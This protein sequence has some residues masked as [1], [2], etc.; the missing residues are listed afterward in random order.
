MLLSGGKDSTYALAQLKEMGL[1]VLAFTL[2]NGY[3]SAEALANVERVAT[4]L[5]VDYVIGKTEAMNAIFV[6]SLQ[7]H[8]NVC[9]GCFKTIYTL[10][11]QLALEKQ[12]PFIV[13]GLSRGQFFETRLTKELFEK[14]EVDV[15][16]IDEMILNARKA[17]HQVDD[18]V[19]E[20][21]DV[22]M[23]DNDYAF[24]KV[25]FLDFYRYTDVS[26]NEM[27]VYLNN[28]LPWVRP[29]DTGRSTNCLINQ[30]GIYIHKKEL[31]YSNYAFP[32]SW[33]VRIGHKTRKES[34]D[35]IN[36]K[37]DEKEVLQIL[38]EIGYT[39]AEQAD[40]RKAQ[41]VAY[42]VG[43]AVEE[44]ELKNYL[45]ARFPDYMIPVQ[46]IPL[47]S[48]PLT[49]NGKIDKAALPLPDAIRPVIATKYQ[50]PQTEFEEIIQE[51]WSEVMDI[52]KIGIYDTFIALG[53]DSLQGIQ[54]ISRLNAAFEL[55]LPV[56]LIFQKPTIAQLAIHIEELMVE[57]MQAFE[58]I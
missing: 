29:S 8:C 40:E 25:Q 42:F 19:K 6:D 54:V 32:Y 20:L 57:I 23:F 10:S 34:L 35:E 38:D 44:V 48:L 39:T 26:L 36:E 4:T 1:S 17:Y 31:G 37:I 45:L 3:I 55:E 47:E 12:I 2:D 11:V 56:N 50:A 49:V 33:D 7:R 13:T 51:I 18:A 21:L 53:G 24:E 5:G 14:E 52:D 43:E 41:L 58:N 22:S 9:D 46:F 28:K 16:K 15:D 27:L 30:A